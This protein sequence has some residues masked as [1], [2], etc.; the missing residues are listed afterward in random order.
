MKSI[1]IWPWDVSSFL[2]PVNDKVGKFG[3]AAILVISSSEKGQICK[4]PPLS[5]S[6]EK[7]DKGGKEVGNTIPVTRVSDLMGGAVNLI[8]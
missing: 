4:T 8:L 6:L 3:E 1:K 2:Q 5:L 7:S